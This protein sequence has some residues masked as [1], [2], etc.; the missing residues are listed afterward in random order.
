MEKY[1]TFN[2]EQEIR[3]CAITNVRMVQKKEAHAPP[4]ISTAQMKLPNWQIRIPN[5][6]NLDYSEYSDLIPR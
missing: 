2:V 6:A 4:L 3:V 1:N 5:K